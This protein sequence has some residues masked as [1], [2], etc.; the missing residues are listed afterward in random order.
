MA[1]NNAFFVKPPSIFDALLA[2]T[3]GYEMARKSGRDTRLQD[4]RLRA[5]QAV[6]SGGD[7]RVPIGELLS[8][9]DVQGAAALG[10]LASHSI[11]A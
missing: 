9:G 7:L 2:G 5:G 1:E 6:Q 3:Q 11:T 10:T 4:A 8:E